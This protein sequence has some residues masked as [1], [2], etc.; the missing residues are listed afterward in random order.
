VLEERPPVFSSTFRIVDPGPLREAG[1]VTLGTATTVEEALA[2]ERAGVDAVVV[3]G[4][5]AGGHRWER[6]ASR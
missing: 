6:P 2:L 4:G 3:Q 1:I 5:E